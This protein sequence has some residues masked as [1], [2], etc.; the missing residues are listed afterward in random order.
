MSDFTIDHHGMP[1]VVVDD[2]HVDYRVLATGRRAGSEQRSSLFERRRE[3][4]VVNALKGISFT[5]YENESIGVIGSNG[6]GKSTLMRAITG[7]TPASKG[8]VYAASRPNMLSVGAAL[9]PDLSGER[10][11]ILGGLALGMS[12]AEVARRYDDI[13]EFTG[14]RDFIRMP[15]RTYSSG[16]SARLKFAIAT[17]TQHDILIVDEALSVGDKEFQDKSEER[18]R[19]IREAA[20]TV[21]LVSHSMPSILDT[22]NR[23]LWLEKG[24]LLMDG[25]P[26][27]V[28][29]AYEKSQRV[30]K[31]G[32]G[33]RFVEHVQ[34]LPALQK[35]PPAQEGQEELFVIRARRWSELLRRSRQ[36][37]VEVVGAD[38]V[39]VVHDVRGEEDRDTQWP[40]GWQV[41]TLDAA[42]LQELGL[43]DGDAGLRYQTGDHALIAAAASFTA[44]R[45]WLFESDAYLA[46]DLPRF[47]DSTRGDDS[48]ILAL[49][50]KSAPEKWTWTRPMHQL[51]YGEVYSC[52][53]PVIRLSAAALDELASARR[54]LTTL[55]HDEPDVVYPNLESFVPTVLQARGF[56]ATDL[57]ELAGVATDTVKFG[58]GYLLP[59]A[60][61]AM[62][63]ERIIY[64]GFGPEEFDAYLA[65]PVVKQ[66]L[67]SA[68]VF[69]F[70][71]EES[72]KFLPRE[73][74]LAYSAR[75]GELLG[76]AVAQ[77]MG[78]EEE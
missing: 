1:A 38:R 41:L 19:Q 62:G 4:L 59:E 60:L 63:G 15:M 14:L 71:V 69:W 20:G 49:E 45:Y 33:L 75:L 73:Y 56:S 44:D 28:V 22:C 31:D 13:V 42:K 68:P 48:G 32:P 5:A 11:I 2:L 47:L 6:S 57:G 8:A 78:D 43:L 51:G 10:N 72:L 29:D 55:V 39:I 65:D 54:H 16:M 23:V 52:K 34:G 37:L 9:L 76:D 46:V 12:K 27:T 61:E 21:F 67:A 64:P 25:D 53:L 50:L 7:L 40:V 18:I 35:T 36:R 24:D 17:A 70:R 3:M 58:V 66:M 77:R 30:P 74:Q 26:Q